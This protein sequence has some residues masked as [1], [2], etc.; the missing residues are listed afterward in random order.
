LI[1]VVGAVL[2][3]RTLTGLLAKG[4]GFDTSSLVS[5]G[6]N[7][8]KSGYPPPCAAR[9][10]RRIDAGIRASAIIESSTVVRFPLLT[11]G[12]WN[13]PMTIQAGRRFATDRD[14]NLNAVTPE[15][16]ATLGIGI[17]EG[18]GFSERDSRPS[19]P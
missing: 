17:V 11:G 4:P 1:L 7:P 8:R 14:V 13:N 9:L 16:F 19:D 5:F 12:S 18:R 6:I 10:F 15:F 3:A 2:F